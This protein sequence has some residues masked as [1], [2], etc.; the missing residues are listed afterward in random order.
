VPDGD[1][2]GDAAPHTVAE[3]IGLFDQPV[4]QQSGDVI[5]HLLVAQ[6]TIY[7]CRSP[8]PL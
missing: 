1:L 4:P 2:K 7:I 3:E 8:M 6:R 5:C